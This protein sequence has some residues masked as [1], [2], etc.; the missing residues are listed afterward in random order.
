MV[1][2]KAALAMAAV[3]V[4]AVAGPLI[5]HAGAAGGQ[6]L[7]FQ[8][9]DKGSRFDYI[10]NA[11]KNKPHAKPRFSVGDEIVLGNPLKDD[12]G[13]AGELR[14]TC[15]ATHAGPA[16]DTGFNTAR[17]ICTGAFVLRDGTLFVETTDT[18]NKSTKGAVVGGT[19]AYV[20][21]RGTFESKSTKTGA[22]DTVTLTG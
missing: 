6:T 4:A 14:A 22:D 19:G 8:E 3:S 11:P 1:P 13:S 16:S 10:D 20:D 2:R 15:T 7:T 5:A 12:K 21:A 18:G 17:P 9:L